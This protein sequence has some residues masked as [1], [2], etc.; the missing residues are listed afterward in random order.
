MV[1]KA[2]LSDVAPLLKLINDY[3]SQGIM[4]PR[5]EF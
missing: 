2:L 3:A 1:R 5:T 4:L